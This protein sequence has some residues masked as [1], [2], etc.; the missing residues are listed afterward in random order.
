MDGI[1]KKRI[2]YL[3]IAKGVG[4]ILMILG[5]VPDLTTASRQFITSFH[6]PLFFFISGMFLRYIDFNTFVIKKRKHYCNHCWFSLYYQQ[7][8]REL[9]ILNTDGFFKHYL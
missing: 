7:L 2:F 5:H 1:E 4:V 8:A 6:M 3:D 9:T